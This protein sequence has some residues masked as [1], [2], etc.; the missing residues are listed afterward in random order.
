MVLL[1]GVASS[2]QNLK[3]HIITH[4]HLDAGW[5]KDLDNCFAVVNKIFSSVLD[6]LL[7]NP[8]RKYT[9][10]DLYFFERWYKT[11]LDDGKR[12]SIRKLV[13]SGQIEILHGGAVSPDEATTT[14]NDIID[15]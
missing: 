11:S 12:F 14:F 1:L 15:N 5:V 7:L 10:G 13:A 6:S 9:V 3:L 4:S 2:K 8:G